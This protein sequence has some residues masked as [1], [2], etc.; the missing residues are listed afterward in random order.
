MCVF[1]CA[2]VR[3]LIKRAQVQHLCV[4]AAAAAASA[5]CA[6]SAPCARAAFAALAAAMAGLPPSIIDSAAA[7]APA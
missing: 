6:A 7:L 5:A 3:E 4:P 1:V 2:N